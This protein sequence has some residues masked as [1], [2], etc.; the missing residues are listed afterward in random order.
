MALCNEFFKEWETRYFD[1]FHTVLRLF[2]AARLHGNEPASQKKWNRKP[3]VPP[4]LL[5]QT[6]DNSSRRLHQPKPII[7]DLLSQFT[8][9]TTREDFAN[10]S[11][12]SNPISK[13][14]EAVKHTDKQPKCAKDRLVQLAVSVLAFRSCHHGVP[15]SCADA[16]ADK[17][18]WWGCG[19]HVPM[20]MD[21]IPDSERCSCEPKVERDGHTYPPQGPKP[22]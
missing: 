21:S 11:L 2:A 6:N 14:I 13:I 17:A 20:V 4:L 15:L 19:Q 7:G 5:T 10:A 9:I 1:V 18:T 12:P 3:P 22:E 8:L 16:N